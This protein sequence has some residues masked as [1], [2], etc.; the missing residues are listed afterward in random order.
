M[1]AFSF[2]SC[3][4]SCTRS[5]QNKGGAIGSEVSNISLSLNSCS[6][7]N[8]SSID[9]GGAIYIDSHNGGMV[10]F[11]KLCIYQCI[12]VS[13]YNIYPNL[14]V[15]VDPNK[16]NSHK[17]ISASSQMLTTTTEFCYGIEQ[18]LITCEN[19]NFSKN[20]FTHYVTINIFHPTSSRILFCDFESNFAQNNAALC[21]KGNQNSIKYINVVNNT[22]KANM[23]DMIHLEDQVKCYISN[24]SFCKNTCYLFGIQQSCSLLVEFSSIE[25][26]S[27]WITSGS[28][29]IT[30][31]QVTY[32]VDI[33]T[34]VFPL[35]YTYYCDEGTPDQTPLA[36]IS[37]TFQE[38]PSNTIGCTPNPSS[39]IASTQTATQSEST[40]SNNH[41]AIY[42]IVSIYV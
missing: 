29:T 10:N 8:C 33:P 14:Y 31:C 19:L 12:C 6:F 30:Q 21:F 9:N 36:T 35:Y 1:G 2:E 7:F 27:I 26:Q 41:Y 22:Q 37:D 4:F 18:G 16:N 25:H 24:S 28:A 40:S 32:Q 3:L 39:T 20:M 38:T 23:G 5:N 17:M 15:C 42:A 13:K 34:S 11:N